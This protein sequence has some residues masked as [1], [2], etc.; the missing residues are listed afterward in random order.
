MLYFYRP[1]LPPIIGKVVANGPAE[2]AGLQANDR[3]LAIDEQGISSWYAFVEAIRDFKGSSLRL[4]L[5]RQ[6]GIVTVDVLPEAVSEHG[7]MVGKIGVAVAEPSTPR[8]HIKTFVRYGFVAAAGK[9]LNETWDQS[10]F[11]LVMMGKMLIGE[12][13]WRNL[14]GPVT[15]ADYAGQSARLGLDYYLKF[16]ALLSV[17][18]GVLNLLPIPVL[19]GGHLLYHMI[20]V[21]RGRPLSERAMEIGLQV[22]MSM[23]FALMAFAFFNDLT[24][25]FNG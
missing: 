13:S 14:S 17:S 5:E 24:R 7:K 11:S 22:G 2:R 19:D 25:L 10:V 23:L 15:I 16:M 18:L 8:R 6:G 9:A 12:V 21:I 20:E 4:K 1:D 3:V